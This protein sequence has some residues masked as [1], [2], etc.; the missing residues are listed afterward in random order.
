MSH[1]TNKGLPRWESRV[2]YVVRH[3]V[4]GKD[5]DVPQQW[6]TSLDEPL[7]VRCGERPGDGPPTATVKGNGVVVKLMACPQC[8]LE[9]SEVT[10]EAFEPYRC[11]PSVM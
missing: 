1:R 2:I 11:S 3:V 9:V 4:A 10:A 5:F 7:C 8:S 6:T